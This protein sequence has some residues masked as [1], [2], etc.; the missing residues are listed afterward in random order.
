MLHSKQDSI[1]PKNTMYAD[2][3]TLE[4]EI[5]TTP[6][7]SKRMP[8]VIITKPLHMFAMRSVRVTFAV[9][10]SRSVG[11]GALGTAATTSATGA[12]LI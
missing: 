4:K 9:D 11:R 8:I 10:H 3:V 1:K 7:S 5:P 6:T 12:S 2:T